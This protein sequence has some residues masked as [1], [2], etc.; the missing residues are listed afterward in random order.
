MSFGDKLLFFFSAL[1]AFNGLLLSIN[2][3]FFPAKKH[4]SNYLLGALLLM[5]SI[6][7]GKSVAYFFD[8]DLPKLYLQVGLTACFLIGPFLYYYIK[9][10]IKQIRKLPRAWIWQLAGWLVT[11]VLVGAVYSYESFPWLWRRYI[12]PIIYL[13]WGVH[14]AFSIVLL[15]PLL[16][17]MVRKEKLRPFENSLLVVCGGVFILFTS[18]VW[19]ILDITKGSYINGAIYFSLII[20]L[21]ISI[22]LYRKKTNDLSSFSAQKYGDKK[23]D[24]DEAQLIISKLKNG[25]A[26]K[27]L[28]KNPDLK[29][30]DLARE[31]NVSGH[32][33]SQLLNDNME[34]GFNLFVNEYRINEACKMLSTHPNLSIDAIGDEVG[35]NSKSTF[36]ST[37]KR[38]KG[39][40]PSVYRASNST[41][42]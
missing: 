10:E 38:I 25:M 20:Y 31:I 23:L 9:S 24:P 17:K 13:Q 36:F 12:V 30:N 6:R 32:Q 7:I 15:M 27:E 19:A 4:L 28:F 22:L 21:V 3:F 8:Y 39:V 37:F 26:T 41:D 18:Y 1:G 35:F 42:L 16:K 14:I 5:L 34:K 33:L 40:S 29:V 2:F 11:I